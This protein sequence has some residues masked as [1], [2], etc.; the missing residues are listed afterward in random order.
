MNIRTLC[1]GLT[2]AA[3]TFSSPAF[4]KDDEKKMPAFKAIEEK[5]MASGK[6]N[7]DPAFGYI[8]NHGSTRFMGTFLKVPSAEEVTE[9]E[10]EWQKGF[11]KAKAKYEKQMKAYPK[12]VAAAKSASMKIPEAPVEPTPENFSI[13]NIETRTTLS[14]GPQFV[15]S[16]ASGFSYLSKVRPGTYIYY[17]P[18]FLTQNGGYS[19]TCYCM[20][21]VKFDVKPG[22]VTNMGDIFSQLLL[23]GGGS[24]KLNPN[25]ALPASLEKLPH[26]NGEI[27]ASGKI[28]NFFGVMIDRLAPIEGVMAYQRDKV[29][30]LK[31]VANAAA[32]PAVI[33]AAAPTPDVIAPAAAPSS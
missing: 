33:P 32:A 9:Y 3:L 27:V 28:D 29:V 12:E 21:T 11:D 15:F 10:A 14:I 5:N 7:F 16:K 13:G 8:F 25:Y 1:L 23:D 24:V 4:A 30:D 20:G 17:G 2:A 22:V 26:E 31:A 19:G 18:L 6:D